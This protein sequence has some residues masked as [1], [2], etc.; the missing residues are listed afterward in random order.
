MILLAISMVLQTVLVQHKLTLKKKDMVWSELKDRCLEMEGFGG[1]LA[2]WKRSM[3][4]VKGTVM[5][6]VF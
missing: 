6:N 5:A 3:G 2:L 1:F 4:R